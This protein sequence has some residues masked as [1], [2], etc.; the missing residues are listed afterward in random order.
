MN[1]PSNVYYYYKKSNI[2]DQN[3][4]KLVKLDPNSYS[5]NSA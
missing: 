4:L 1:S 2:N 5:D 3:Q